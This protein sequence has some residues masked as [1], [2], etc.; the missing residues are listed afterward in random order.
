MKVFYW[1]TAIGQMIAVAND[2]AQA[3]EQVMATLG[4]SD[5]ARDELRRAISKQPQIITSPKAVV[6]YIN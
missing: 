1:D 5:Y 4:E 3:R 2:V 6:A